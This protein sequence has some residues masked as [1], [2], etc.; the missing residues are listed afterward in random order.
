MAVPKTAALPLGDTPT[1]TQAINSVR[2]G[3]Q[4]QNGVKIAA[5]RPG[6]KVTVVGLGAIGFF[7]AQILTQ[8]GHDTTA[9]DLSAARVEAAANV[10]IKSIQINRNLP[11]RDQVAAV[12]PLDV[13]VDCTGVPALLGE[14]L[15]AGKDLDWGERNER[16]VRYL[17]Q[18]SY[19]G[20]FTVPYNDAFSKEASLYFP[21][22]N[23][24]ADIR[25]VLERMGRGE[26]RL[27]EQTVQ[28]CQ[29][30]LAQAVYDQLRA[31]RDMPLSVL[32]SWE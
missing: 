18:G 21:R 8:D 4:R 15:K 1:G 5:L 10:G 30:A 27:P 23:R 14:L 16:G 26:L 13:I 32:F 19:P 3:M 2:F 6:E 28:V 9:F 24:P 25:N 20:D 22:D 12:G 11:T 31:A 29:P 7:A 17:V